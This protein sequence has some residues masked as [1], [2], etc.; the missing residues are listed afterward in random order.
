M[1][2]MFW[3]GGYTDFKNVNVKQVKTDNKVA[4]ALEKTFGLYIGLYTCHGSSKRIALFWPEKEL[5]YSRD[6]LN[7]L[8]GEATSVLLSFDHAIIHSFGLDE[9]E[10]SIG[11]LLSRDRL[12]EKTIV[13]LHEKNI[14]KI[15]R[16]STESELIIKLDLFVHSR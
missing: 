16:F 1:S 4:I 5:C 2:R 11:N 14:I 7:N 6:L 9:L 8:E 13:D 15:P 3:S 12:S 10:L